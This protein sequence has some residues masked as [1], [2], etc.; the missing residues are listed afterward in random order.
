MAPQS[1]PREA[2]PARA[3]RVP[4]A[5]LAAGF[6]HAFVAVHCAVWSLM[7]LFGPAMRGARVAP[8]AVIVLGA[9]GAL[10]C[11]RAALDAFRFARPMTPVVQDVAW[12]VAV[13]LAGFYA[14][15][16][17]QMWTLP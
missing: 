16:A 6:A 7:Y 10:A 13:A 3:V 5:R 4:Y 9:A 11:V 2:S 1:S 12:T 15:I 14:L 17:L 8:L